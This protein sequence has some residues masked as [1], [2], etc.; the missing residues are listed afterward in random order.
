MQKV[1]I[2][3]A[4]D[5]ER[6]RALEAYL[7]MEGSTLQKKL[8]EAVG[9]LYEQMVPKEVQKYVEA[10]SGGKPKPAPKPKPKTEMKKEVVSDGQP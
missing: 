8:E 5:E 3:L 9:Q 4:L 7:K 2:I 1:N 6:L 10:L